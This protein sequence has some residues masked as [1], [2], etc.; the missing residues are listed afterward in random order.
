MISKKVLFALISLML[1]LSSQT[2]QSFYIQ[3]RPTPIKWSTAEDSYLWIWEEFKNAPGEIYGEDFVFWGSSLGPYHNYTELTTKLVLLNN[4]FPELVDVFSIG[5]TWQNR[6]IWC[7][8]LTNESVTTAKTEYYVVGAHHARELITVEN[9]LYF[10]DWIIYNSYYGSVYDSL[11]ASKEIYVIPM[12]NPDGISIL[13]WYPEQR[14]NMAPID[15]DDDGSRADEYERVY[16]WNNETN[17]SAIREQDLDENGGI[18]ED[19]PGGVDLNRNYAAFWGLP[20]ASPIPYFDDYRGSKP[21][22]EPETQAM[23]S[24]MYNHSFNYA[25]SLHSGVQ[26]I[27]SP[28]SINGSLPERDGGEYE[29]LLE[30]LKS[31][32]DFPLW[33]ETNYG[34]ATSGEWG[35]YAYLYH[36]IMSFT[37]ETYG[38]SPLYYYYDFF[39]PD[40]DE[41]LA[42]CEKIF[43]ALEF[44]ANEP[45]L[46]YANSLP[47]IEVNNP[48]KINQ[49]FDNYTITW[50]AS[51]IDGDLLNASVFVSQDG[52]HWQL[53]K[54]NLIDRTYLL[55]DLQ[56]FEAGSYYIKVAVSDGKDWIHDTTE[57]KLNVKKEVGEQKPY[58]F[59]IAAG[60]FGVLAMLYYAHIAKKTKDI[61]K[62]W[63]KEI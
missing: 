22:S 16:Y 12:L 10:I 34:Y 56:D 1:I 32:L 28:W 43:P 37:I 44:L 60:T 40:A 45:H 59:W 48:S 47:E 30:E 2:I 46:T 42:N 7:V 29:A 62:T 51:D 36:D 5:L 3:D 20:G 49:V 25:V 27:I 21:F 63:G 4:S 14:K 24:F 23:R 57:I 19:R 39:N 61:G 38:S 50:S 33:N 54:S 8:R 6:S 11:L 17:T 15:D 26:A 35:D 55:W 18:G 58:V 31:I 52:L 13:H 53:L 9:A 41:V